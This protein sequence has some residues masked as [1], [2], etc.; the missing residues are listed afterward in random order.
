M[1]Q[2]VLLSICYLVF[3]SARAEISTLKL[4]TLVPLPEPAG[5]P[6]R[7]A[8]HRGEELISAAQLHGSEEDKH[9]K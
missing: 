4:L 1:E 7:L 3:A 9:E 2:L 5:L 6:S 8:Y